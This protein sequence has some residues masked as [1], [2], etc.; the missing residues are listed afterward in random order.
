[1]GFLDRIFGK[2]Q[3]STEDAIAVRYMRYADKI[4]LAGQNI[5]GL[6]GATRDDAR[7]LIPFL[8]DR[9]Q[10]QEKVVPES[11]ATAT[12][13]SEIADEI[14]DF[15]RATQGGTKIRRLLFKDGRVIELMLG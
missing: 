5:I 8:V 15:T 4:D 10:M 13:I 1:M 14:H 11:E 7:R 2:A 9:D 3:A 12:M 6:S